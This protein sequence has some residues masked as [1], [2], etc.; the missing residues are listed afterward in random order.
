MVINRCKGCG[1]YRGMRGYPG[2]YVCGHC[3]N[4]Q[5]S[6]PGQASMTPNGSEKAQEATKTSET[7][8]SKGK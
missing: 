6:L 2:K 1:V 5:D 3:G 4:V 8:D 7:V